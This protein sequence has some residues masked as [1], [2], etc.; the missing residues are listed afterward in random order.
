MNIISECKGVHRCQ[1]LQLDGEEEEEGEVGD[2]RR[3]RR[4]GGG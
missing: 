1:V 2:R 4:R 3:R